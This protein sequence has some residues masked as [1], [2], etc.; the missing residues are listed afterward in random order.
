MVRAANLF[1]A[2][3]VTLLIVGLVLSNLVKKPQHMSVIWP[4]SHTG[5]IIGCEVPCYGLAGLFAVFAFSYTL[6]WIR[7][8]ETMV[9]WHLGLSLFGAAMFGF[10]FALLTR[11]AAEGAGRQAG[12]WTLLTIAAGLLAGPAI[13]VVGQLVLLVAMIGA[14][15]AQRH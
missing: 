13:F 8:S 6:R 10:G 11:V 5:Y 3:S 7:M 4:G 2:A 15:A 12:Q 1:A 9:D 14:Y